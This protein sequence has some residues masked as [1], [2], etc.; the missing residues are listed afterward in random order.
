MCIE[1]LMYNHII[2][3]SYVKYGWYG[4]RVDFWFL[5]RTGKRKVR[6]LTHIYWYYVV[7]L[8]DYHSH[9]KIKGAPIDR[10]AALSVNISTK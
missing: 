10:A 2:L 1:I 3:S 9:L 5:I 8:F 4:C 6:H 7:I